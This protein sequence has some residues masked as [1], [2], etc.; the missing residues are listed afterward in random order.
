MLHRSLVALTA[1]LWI[2]AACSESPRE[3]DSLPGAEQ[4]ELMNA[5]ERAEEDVGFALIRPMYLPEGLDWQP[6]I[7]YANDKLTVIMRF[8]P[9]PG[10][11]SVNGDPSAPTLLELD[12]V[13]E[14]DPSGTFNIGGELETLDLGDETVQV[15]EFQLGEDAVGFHIHFRVG[16]VFVTVSAFWEVAP[17][18]PLE[19]S[20]EMK[21]ELIAVAE[22]MIARD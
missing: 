8:F 21:R 2:S 7:H 18:G 17:P 4:F 11:T 16:D 12:V 15:Q 19:V 9:T 22:S 6:E 13:Q 3:P 10:D 1:A 20:D 5:I 14:H